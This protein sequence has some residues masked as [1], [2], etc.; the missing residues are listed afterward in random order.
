MGWKPAVVGTIR[1]GVVEVESTVSVTVFVSVTVLSLE[2][3]KM[4]HCRACS[5]W[6]LPGCSD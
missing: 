4:S 2:L 1:A 3:A 6:N 5:L